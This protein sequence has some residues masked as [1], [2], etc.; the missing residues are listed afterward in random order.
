MSKDFKIG[1]L[2]KIVDSE[3]ENELCEIIHINNFEMG[4]RYQ[5]KYPDVYILDGTNLTSWVH[6]LD[7][8]LDVEYYRDHK[9]DQVLDN[10]CHYSDLPS[11]GAYMITDDDY[12]DDLYTDDDSYTDTHF[13]DDDY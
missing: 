9:L 4:S 11:P 1:D 7:L 5:V 8:V 13:D 12:D 2:V 10:Y 6:E 3:F